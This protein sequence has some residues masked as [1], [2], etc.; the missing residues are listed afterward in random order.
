VASAGHISL[1]ND[2]GLTWADEHVHP[3]FDARIRCVE[4]VCYAL[5]SELGSEWNGLMITEAG[6]NHWKL[7]STFGLSALAQALAAYKSSGV[8]ESFGATAMIATSEGVYVAGI[9]NAGKNSSGAVFRVPRDGAITAIGHT[10]PEGLWVLERGPDGALWA[11][12]E[13]AF[14]YEAGKWVNAWSAPG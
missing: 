1:S 8:V 7:L 2:D 12:G 5:L 14:R 4:R 10:V 11:G 9:V 6:S 13:G 3:F